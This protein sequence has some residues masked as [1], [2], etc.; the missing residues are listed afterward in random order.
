MKFT[1][2]IKNFIEHVYQRAYYSYYKHKVMSDVSE[3]IF[4]IATRLENKYG[5]PATEKSI[6]AYTLAWERYGR[7]PTLE[8]ILS[9]MGANR[10]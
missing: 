2:A 10:H 5:I 3:K 4:K 6:I 1:K 9:F 8:E 7:E